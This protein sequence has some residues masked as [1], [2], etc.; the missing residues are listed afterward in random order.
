[1]RL[2]LDTCA[3]IWLTTDPTRLSQ[4]A[5]IA[6]E[7]SDE[8]IFVSEASVWEIVLKHRTGKIPLPDVPRRW[9]PAELTFHGIKRKPITA[10]AIYL[11][12]EHRDP[13]D[14]IIA[15]QSIEYGLRLVSSDGAFRTLGINPLW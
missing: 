4:A 12:G 5:R 6:I 15:A 13:F 8:D 10:E 11:P 7:D 3:F 14:R 2:L 9:L 1:M